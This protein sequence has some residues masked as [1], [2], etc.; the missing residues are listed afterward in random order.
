MTVVV[1]GAGVFGLTAALELKRRGHPVVVVE[2][3]PVPH[4]LAASTDVT[5][6]VRLDYG[7]DAL[8]AKLGARAI[9]GWRAW[10]AAWGEEVY[11]ETGVL[12]MARDPLAPGG[13]EYESL[14][15]LAALGFPVERVGVEA[16]ARRF[17]AWA[18]GVHVDGY[19][20]P[21][22]GWVDSARAIALLYSEARRSGVT[23]R[24]D[25]AIVGVLEEGGRVRGALTAEGE[26]IEGEVTVVAAGAWT[27]RLLPQ[28]APMMRV[29][30][31]PVLRFQ[32]PD[33]AAL[34]PPLFPVWGADL[35]RTGW[36]GFP[37]LADGTLKIAH[38]GR[39]VPTDPSGPR[40]LEA[41][42][43]ARFRAFLRETL[44]G[45]AEAPIA[46]RRSC[47]Y[48]DTLDG[49]F[50]IDADPQRPGLVVASGGSGHAFKFAPV[51]G[52]V[53]AD[54]VEGRVQSRFAWRAGAPKREAARSEA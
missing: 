6:V 30:G 2:P 50:L 38:H 5:K 10:N 46:A 3:G 32:V 25:E 14:Q 52:A 1:V 48:A 22:G 4:P 43:E 26:R 49:D 21:V 41:G 23:L 44:P 54:A 33:V 40:E 27:P 15:T 45:V 13:F 11:R 20:N 29:V 28:V 19:Y 9:E 8:Y 51:L 7:P 42:V 16:I 24:I 47:L 12:F 37:R 31:Q 39:G 53:I 18:R 35:S 36:Y 17:P 34:R